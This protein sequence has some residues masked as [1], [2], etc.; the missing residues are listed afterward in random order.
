M[1]AA[2]ACPFNGNA[3]DRDARHQGESEDI[4]QWMTA[5][6]EEALKL[7]PP[8]PDGAFKMAATGEKSAAIYPPRLGRWN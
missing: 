6:A 5:P 7:Q 4:E 1:L 8:L 2:Q 3:L